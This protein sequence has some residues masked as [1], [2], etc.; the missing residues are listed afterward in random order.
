MVTGVTRPYSTILDD[1]RQVIDAR[2]GQRVMGISMLIAHGGR[3]VLVAD[4]NVIDMPSAEELAD[5]AVQ[6]AATAR[7]LGHEPRVAMLAYSSFGHPLGDRSVYVRE[8][9]RLL[10]ERG[11]DFEYEGDMAADVALNREAMARYPFCRLSEPANVLVMPAIHSASIST[12]MLRNW[13]RQRLS[14]RYWSAW[15]SRC[16]LPALARP[17]LR[18]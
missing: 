8:A 5:I 4:T 13:A 14:A 17:Q 9:V 11:V 15:T 12:K 2:P 7:A 18:C 3:T 6:T 10:D 1:V 16:R